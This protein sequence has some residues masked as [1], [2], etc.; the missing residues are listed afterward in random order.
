MRLNKFLAHAGVASRRRSDALI[1][2]A[3]TFVNGELIIDPAYPVTETD[4]IVFEG[5][6]L[7]I[8]KKSQVICITHLPQVACFADQHYK[9]VK[10]DIEE[11][12]KTSIRRLDEKQKLNELANM[13]GGTKVGKAA[14]KNAQELI[15]DSK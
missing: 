12:T 3:T 11:T 15:E 4:D 13:L 6:K 5:I 8:S 2:K 1:Q 7:S 14:F 9:V 10:D